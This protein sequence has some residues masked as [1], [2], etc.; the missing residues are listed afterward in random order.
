MA[1]ASHSVHI[2]VIACTMRC[3][4]FDTPHTIRA[5]QGIDQPHPPTMHRACQ[6]AA[7]R[8]SGLQT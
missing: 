7:A 6:D 1:T 8:D 3:V 2:R 5:A 4:V